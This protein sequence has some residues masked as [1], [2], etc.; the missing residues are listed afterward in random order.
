MMT[1]FIGAFTGAFTGGC[2]AV[3]AIVLY[4]DS[5]IKQYPHYWGDDDD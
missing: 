4:V 5:Q 1:F 3:I 2:V